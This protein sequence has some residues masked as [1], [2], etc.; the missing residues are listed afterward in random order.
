MDP[1]YRSSRELAVF[2]VLATQPVNLAVA[3]VGKRTVV[4][5]GP[6]WKQGLKPV[7]AALKAGGKAAGGLKPIQ[8]I[9]A[10]ALRGGVS[11]VTVIAGSSL[12]ADWARR[13]TTELPKLA[14]KVDPTGRSF[15]ARMLRRMG[16]EIGSIA[17]RWPAGGRM[18]IRTRTAGGRFHWDVHIDEREVQS[19]LF[20]FMLLMVR[21]AKSAPPPSPP[22]P[23]PVKRP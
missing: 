22:V 12:L 10:K 21:S 20:P 4:Y 19:A 7:I 3:R 11:S 13:C 17:S 9:A 5:W 6:D 8:R 14:K 2:D 18:R 23:A 1:F 16:R 15:D